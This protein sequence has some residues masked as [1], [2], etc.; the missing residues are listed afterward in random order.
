MKLHVTRR[1]RP[2]GLVVLLPR[3]HRVERPEWYTAG[4]SVLLLAW[5]L[6]VSTAIPAQLV[7]VVLV[8]LAAGELCFAI[9]TLL[10]LRNP[11]AQVVAFARASRFG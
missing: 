11:R 9:R 8:G 2:D 10:E 5:G 3:D 4:F 6:F 7:A 1:R